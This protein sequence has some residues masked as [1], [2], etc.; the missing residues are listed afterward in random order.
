MTLDPYVWEVPQGWHPVEGDVFAH[1][2][3]CQAAIGWYE[4][5][6]SKKRAPFNP[7]G[8]SHFATCPQA[9]QWRKKR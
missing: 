2:R 9:D 1:C 8:T 5:N 3:S 7:D 4:H 6:E